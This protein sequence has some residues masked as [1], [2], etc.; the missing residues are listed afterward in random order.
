MWWWI[1]KCCATPKAWVT[2]GY[3]CQNGIAV[4]PQILQDLHLQEIERSIMWHNENIR[5][6]IY[7]MMYIINEVVGHHAGNCAWW[8]PIN[9]DGF[10]ILPFH[11]SPYQD[12]NWTVF[13]ICV[14]HGFVALYRGRICSSLFSALCHYCFLYTTFLRQ[15]QSLIFEGWQSKPRPAFNSCIN[16]QICRFNNNDLKQCNFYAQVS[17]RAVGYVKAAHPWRGSPVDRTGDPCCKL[18]SKA[19]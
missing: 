17:C 1:L 2:E 6:M 19:C 4:L 15:L 12:F 9:E 8:L 5:T 3:D 18:V 7:C 11:S 13:R 10:I 14:Y 16:R